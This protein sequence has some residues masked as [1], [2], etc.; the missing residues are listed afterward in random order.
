MSIRRWL[1]IVSLFVLAPTTLAE[2]AAEVYERFQDFDQNGDGIVEIRSV[3]VEAV[4]GEAGPLVLVL[5]EPRLL[6]ALPD[7]PDLRPLLERFANDLG[8]EGYQAQVLSVELGESDLHQDGRFV[9]ALREVLRAANAGDELAGAVLVGRFPDAFIVRT[10]NWRKRGSITLHKGTDEQATYENVRYLRRVP[11]DVAR[12]A[13][14]VLS[15]LDGAWESVYVQP[16]VKLQIT[17][18]VFEGNVPKYGGECLD[19]EQKSIAY[20]DFFHVSD[21][22]LEVSR[23]AAADGEEGR[24]WVTLFDTSGD[25]ECSSLDRQRPNVIARPD[26]LVS[27][28]D[29][30]GTALV[31]KA[32]VVG[33][34]GSGLLDAEG[35]PRTVQFASNEDVPDWRSVWEFSPQLERQLLAEYFERNHAYRS[36]SA[37]I[38]WRPA[39]LACDLGSGYRI[40]QRAADDWVETDAKQADVRGR[41]TLMQVADWFA[42]PALLRTVRAHSDPWGSNFKKAN[43][44]ALDARLGGPAWSWT[45][46]GDSLV[47]SL[48]AAC[49]GGRLDWFLLRSLWEY[50]LV[51]PEPAFYLYTGCNG[52]SPPGGGGRPFDHPSYGDRQG[53]EAMLFHG[54]GLALVGRAK[55]FYD[56]PR[57]FA[58]TLGA[59]ETFG[60]AWARYFDLESQAASWGKAGGDIGRKR[61][62]FWSVLGD[63]TLRLRRPEA[64]TDQ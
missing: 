18:A 16:R 63:W 61:S 39:S 28:L 55:V 20:E 15:D 30:R 13:D 62:Y 24:P 21:G 9:L 5:V 59:G 10:C 41:P 40:M 3:T 27:R 25:H 48:A 23:T 8:E 47:P 35:Q 11:E 36:G 64:G 52:V 7:A 44:S 32:S 34:D 2:P 6:E 22:K 51:A 49:G 31:P 33:V 58:E 19:F 17:L 1:T 12:R 29:A 43:A 46:R 57:G 38:A 56:E 4:A 45:K 42:Y 14:I 60:A 50:G 53:A 54:N 37:A 26:I